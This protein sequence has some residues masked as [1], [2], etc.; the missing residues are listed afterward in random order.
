[1]I[2]LNDI[3]TFVDF[4]RSI[5]WVSFSVDR[6]SSRE[7]GLGRPK[8]LAL[9]THPGSRYIEVE[10]SEREAWTFELEKPKRIP[11]GQREGLYKLVEKEIKTMNLFVHMDREG[12]SYFVP[13]QTQLPFRIPQIMQLYSLIFW[14][15]SLVRYDP[16]SVA[17]LQD[18][19]YWILIDGFLNQSVMWLLELFEWQLYQRQRFL[20]RVR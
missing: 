16:H 6:E 2:R 14:L 20:K 19:Q 9:I 5:L 3:D 15:G 10:P 12:I 8:F 13:V 4:S 11:K 18:S 1:L 7:L 17:W